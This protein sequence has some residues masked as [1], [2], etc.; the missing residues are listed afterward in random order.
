MYRSITALL[1]LL[2]E[3]L[4]GRH[5]VVHL[6]WPTSAWLDRMATGVFVSNVLRLPRLFPKLA[7]RI[8]HPASAQRGA[9]AT[10]PPPARAGA[11]VA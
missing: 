7:F 1:A 6:G 10:V 2:D 5:I 4:G 11:G 8:E 3:E 9:V